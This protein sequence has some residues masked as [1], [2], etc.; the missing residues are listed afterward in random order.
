[1]RIEVRTGRREDERDK[2]H[3]V[4]H[5]CDLDPWLL[6]LAVSG[7]KSSSI[8]RL[9]VRATDECLDVSDL[10]LWMELAEPLTCPGISDAPPRLR[11]VG[12]RRHVGARVLCR[13]LEVVDRFLQVE[14]ALLKALFEP[15]RIGLRLF[16]FRRHAG[17]LAEATQGT[18]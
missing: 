14:G 13:H 12:A 8:E 2:A 7:R 15:L 6:V 11:Y 3:R 9:E 1:M 5:V 16:P 17:S 10:T 18:V 4:A